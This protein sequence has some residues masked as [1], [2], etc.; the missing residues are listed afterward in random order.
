MLVSTIPVICSLF[1]LLLVFCAFI[2]YGIFLSIVHSKWM[3]LLSVNYTIG[4]YLMSYILVNAQ[5]AWYN[6]MGVCY[7]IVS[8]G[9]IPFSIMTIQASLIRV[10]APILTI[11]YS[12]FV[13]ITL[14]LYALVL[15]PG[16]LFWILVIDLCDNI[17][18]DGLT[19]KAFNII[20]EILVVCFTG[21][22]TVLVLTNDSKNIM[23]YCFYVNAASVLLIR[24]CIS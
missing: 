5:S 17:L 11:L 6:S 8:I 22:A 3:V 21:L 14:K 9:M 2:L 24:L 15:I 4:F 7:A 20:S 23:Y 1:H 10:F 18:K 12:I 19:R 13:L 16:F